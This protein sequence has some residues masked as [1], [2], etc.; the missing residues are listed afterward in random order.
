MAVINGAVSLA[1]ARRWIAQFSTPP[2]IRLDKSEIGIGHCV[3]VEADAQ[4]GVKF[5]VFAGECKAAMLLSHT[6]KLCAAVAATHKLLMPT[7]NEIAHACNTRGDRSIPLYIHD[8]GV[9][10]RGH[11]RITPIRHSSSA[12]ADMVV[13][14][15]VSC[16]NRHEY[17]FL[18]PD[19]LGETQAIACFFHCQNALNGTI[20]YQKD[21][22]RFPLIL[23]KTS[24][25]DGPGYVFGRMLDTRFIFDAM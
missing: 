14:T 15:F 24:C 2:L 20:H 22:E 12:P 18:V 7:E 9:K 10:K 6:K 3:S 17:C 4:K 13:W 16:V 21:F 23:G 25:G 5:V 11:L 8:G 19:S 1:C